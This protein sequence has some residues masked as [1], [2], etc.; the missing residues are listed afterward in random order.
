MAPRALWKAQLQLAKI[1]LPERLYSAQQDKNV[2]FNLLHVKDEE[3]AALAPKKSR[4]IALQ[5]FCARTDLHEALFERGYVL[6]PAEAGT[7]A[8]KLLSEAMQRADRAGIATFVLRERAYIVAI[9]AHNGV[10]LAETL[11]FADELRAPKGVGL[12]KREAPAKSEVSR[13]A[14]ALL[15]KQRGRFDVHKLVDPAHAKLEQLLAAKKKRGEVV[16]AADVTPEAASQGAEVVDLMPML[17]SSLQQQ[18]KSTS[19]RRQARG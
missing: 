18:H 3:L 1:N 17:K 5:S 16:E 13:M 14:R 19:S 4:E 9:L 12:P 15:E 2:H 7:K 6:V 10:L 11:R 8:Y